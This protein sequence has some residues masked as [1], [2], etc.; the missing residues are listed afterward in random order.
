MNKDIKDGLR[1]IVDITDAIFL[2]IN[3][4]EIILNLLKRDNDKLYRSAFVISLNPPLGKE[5]KYL[6]EKAE[7]P[8]RLVVTTL[9]E[10]KEWIGISEII[11]RRDYVSLLT[12]SLKADTKTTPNIIIIIPKI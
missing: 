5:F 4:I 2:S 8:K 9:D 10:A 3:S 12:S 7:N 1:V 11:I 6:L